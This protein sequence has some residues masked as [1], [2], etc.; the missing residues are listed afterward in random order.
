[1]TATGSPIYSTQRNSDRDIIVA[2]EVP[3][4]PP[5]EQK[6]SWLGWGGPTPKLAQMTKYIAKNDKAM[7]VP[8]PIHVDFQ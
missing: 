2:T 7:Y 3:F 5:E 8:V 6:R 1:M 4:M